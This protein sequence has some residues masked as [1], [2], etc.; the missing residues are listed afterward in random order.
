MNY[1][2][3]RRVSLLVLSLS[4][5]VCCSH[6]D[7]HLLLYCSSLS[8]LLLNIVYSFH[9]GFFSFSY[10]YCLYD[11]FL[12][13]DIPDFLEVLCLD[14]FRFNFFLMEILTASTWPSDLKFSLPCH[15]IC[16][17]GFLFNS[18]IFYFE[19]YFSF[20]FL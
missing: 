1:Y 13:H 20:A 19:F 2:I 17:C 6:L 9:L 10:V 18:Y 4:C 3:T 7:N 5:S 16:W 11:F 14:S 15:L 8:M 12:C